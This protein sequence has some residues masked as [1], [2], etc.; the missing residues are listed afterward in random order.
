[1]YIKIQLEMHLFMSQLKFTSLLKPTYGM[2]NVSFIVNHIFGLPCFYLL[3]LSWMLLVIISYESLKRNGLPL[4]PGIM[5]L[6]CSVWLLKESLFCHEQ[7][8][9]FCLHVCLL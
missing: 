4:A 6:K 5:L 3:T 8:N 7:P 2:I 1:M 9:Y